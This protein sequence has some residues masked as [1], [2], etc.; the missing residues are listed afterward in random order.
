MSSYRVSTG[1]DVVLGSLTVLS[2]QPDEDHPGGLQYARV[3]HAA[4]GSLVQEGPYFA[5]LWE[6]LTATQYST[7][8]GLFGLDS[9]TTAN[10]TV[11][12]RDETYANWV[13]KNGLAI[14]PMPGEGVSW[15]YRPRNVTIIVRDLEDAA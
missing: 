13:R 14:R 8:L 3:Q 9:A 1:H 6:E 12:I 5:F 7:I 15:E 10:V 11:Y 4:D 2:P